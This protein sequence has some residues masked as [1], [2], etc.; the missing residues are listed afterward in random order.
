VTG[1]K[2]QPPISKSQIALL[3]GGLIV[4]GAM[5]WSAGWG[6]HFLLDRQTTQPTT[7]PTLAPAALPSV[8]HSPTDTPSPSPTPAPTQPQTST[9][10]PTAATSPTA[11][12]NVKVLSVIP[13]DRGLY[14]V[15]RRACGLPKSHILRPGE[16]IVQATWQLNGFVVEDPDIHLGQEIQVPTYLCP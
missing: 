8:A 6:A 9:P 14:D 11:E 13:G 3:I 1:L 16:E 7:E 5:A 12:H 10:L 4:L 15:V 2:S